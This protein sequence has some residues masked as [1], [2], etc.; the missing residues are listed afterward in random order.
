MR[1]LSVCYATWNQIGSETDLVSLVIYFQKFDREILKCI[2][3]EYI[4][5]IKS[6]VK[7]SRL[8]LGNIRQLQ[9]KS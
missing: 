3:T 9:L 5:D 2:K 1:P 4:F 7:I 6:N 8:K